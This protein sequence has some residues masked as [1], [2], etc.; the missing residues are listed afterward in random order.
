MSR[1]RS[2]PR[3]DTAANRF[4]ASSATSSGLLSLTLLCSQA[5]EL[6][7]LKDMLYQA[8]IATRRAQRDLEVERQARSKTEARLSMARAAGGG[9]GDT[10]AAKEAIVK[11]RRGRL[12]S[13]PPMI[14]RISAAAGTSNTTHEQMRRHH[15]S[16]C[17]PRRRRPT[18]IGRSSR[19][20][21]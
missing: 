1:Q 8:E 21:T 2:P 19:S 12:R 10:E 20:A 5:A 14:R 17:A 13:R 4:L 7:K 3:Q 18:L 15:A 11:A 9:A 16:S 6:V